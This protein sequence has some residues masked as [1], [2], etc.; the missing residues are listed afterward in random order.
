MREHLPHLRTAAGTMPRPPVGLAR[1]LSDDVPRAWRRSA[2]RCRLA[3]F[4]PTCS[5]LAILGWFPYY[6]RAFPSAA[7]LR[8]GRTPDLE[9][10]GVVQRWWT[11]CS[12]ASISNS[13]LSGGV[14]LIEISSLLYRY[15]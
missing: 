1:G 8:V 9:G 2:G 12:V 13:A 7:C 14:A 6:L 11:T 4:F 5:S 10:G 15:Q 3:A